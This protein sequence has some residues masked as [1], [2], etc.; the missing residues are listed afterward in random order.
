MKYKDEFGER[1]KSYEEQYDLRLKKKMPVLIRIDGKAFHTWTKGLKKPFDK[2]LVCSMQETMLELCKHIEGCVFGYC[3]SDEI[4]L[5]LVDYASEDQSPWFDYRIQ[6]I[7]SVAASMATKYFAEAFYYFANKEYQEHLT[8]IC[9]NIED[10]EGKAIFCVDE[11]FNGEAL[12][13]EEIQEEIENLGLETETVSMSPYDFALVEKMDDIPCFDAR[14]FN[15]PIEDVCNAVYWRQV[16]A[17]RNSIQACG[18]TYFSH[19]ELF[20]KKTSDIK[21]MLLEMKEPLNWDED[22]PLFLQRGSACRKVKKYELSDKG[23]NGLP[24]IIERNEWEIDFEMPLLK[25]EDRKY[26]E[27]LVFVGKYIHLKEE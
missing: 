24:N 1:I 27:D 20:K 2:V 19:S 15:V 10:V 11:N 7:S 9:G 4:T 26:L 5:V 16:D 17:V 3:Q 8:E 14:C 21:Q 25:G 23:I 13:L 6:K 18:Q 22:I 12:E